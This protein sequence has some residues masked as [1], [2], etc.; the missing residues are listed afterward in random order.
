MDK[1]NINADQEHA[2]IDKQ[3]YG[4]FSEHLGQ[5]FYDGYWVGEDSKI[6]NVPRNTNTYHWKPGLQ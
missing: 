5:C 2:V 6:P 1:L 4:H 3:I